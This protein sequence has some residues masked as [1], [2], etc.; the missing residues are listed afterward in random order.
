MNHGLSAIPWFNSAGLCLCCADQVMP[1]S[2]AKMWLETG[3]FFVHGV[4]GLA[5]APDPLCKG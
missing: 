1:K 3:F 2:L 5:S 4:S